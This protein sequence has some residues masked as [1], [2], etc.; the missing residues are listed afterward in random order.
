[1]LAGKHAEPRSV[2]ISV[3]FLHTLMEQRITAVMF[4]CFVSGGGHQCDETLAERGGAV[5]YAG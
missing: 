3:L 1:M 4:V 2:V 5:L